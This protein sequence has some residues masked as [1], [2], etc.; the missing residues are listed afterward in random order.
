VDTTGAATEDTA[1]EY[2]S[3]VGRVLGQLLNREPLAPTES[4][5]AAG[6]DSLAAARASLT[7]YRETGTRITLSEFMAEPTPLA[8]ASRLALGPALKE[9]TLPLPELVE[10][11]GDLPLTLRQAGRLARYGLELPPW[12]TAVQAAYL[13]EGPLDQERLAAAANQVVRRHEAFRT[14]IELTNGVP[15]HTLHEAPR[16]VTVTPIAQPVSA[17]GADADAAI[18]AIVGDHARIPFD[19]TDGPLLRISVMPVGEIRSVLLIATDHFVADG[20]TLSIVLSELSAAAHGKDL[21]PAP[22]LHYADFAGWQRKL[23]SGPARERLSAY[24]REA[25]AGVVP[26]FPLAPDQVTGDHAPDDGATQQ[27][28]LSPATLRAV[29]LAARRADVSLFTAFAGSWA[30]VLAADCGYSPVTFLSP[31]SARSQPGLESAAGDLS[32]SAPLVFRLD[33]GLT[34]AQLLRKA[35]TIGAG[36]LA[37]GMF[38]YDEIM[39]VAAEAAPLP[40][41]LVEGFFSVERPVRFSLPGAEVTPILTPIT[42]S[43]FALSLVVSV[44]SEPDEAV[45]R[46]IYK[47]ALFTEHRIGDLLA[48]LERVLASGAAQP[49]A[50]IGPAAE[51]RA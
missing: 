15:R 43:Y 19:L 31:Y 22:E 38:P 9:R 18:A 50:A 25:L 24:W 51:L 33:G 7:L 12:R 37:S 6:G 30:M 36:L 40:S 32:N 23:T 14:R 46:V 21:D 4:F 49:A 16:P 27:R 28:V 8:L 2:T 48:R 39:K 34:Y 17:D 42:R 11:T 3:L 10:R 13:V 45:L 5:V 44:S 1:T 41:P 47:P 20:G 29:R 35:H 26:Q